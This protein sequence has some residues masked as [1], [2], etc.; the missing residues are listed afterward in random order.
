MSS[1]LKDSKLML[2]SSPPSFYRSSVKKHGVLLPT[3]PTELSITSIALL[4]ILQTDS[5]LC[6]GTRTLSISTVLKPCG[7]S[8]SDL[9]DYQCSPPFHSL[10]SFS[11]SGW[12]LSLLSHLCGTGTGNPLMTPQSS[13]RPSQWR[14]TLLL[15]TMDLLWLTELIFLV[16]FPWISS[17]FVF[18][19]F[20]IHF[21]Y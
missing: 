11:K 6:T 1:K 18:H 21:I 16:N 13:Q 7:S 12:S 15:Q 2:E 9:M 10:V 3:P 4:E 17:T 19:N 8:S 20:N 5:I 14:K